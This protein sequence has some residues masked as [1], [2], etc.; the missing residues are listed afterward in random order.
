M[1]IK[2]WR[3]GCADAT[4]ISFMDDD[5]QHKNLF[6]DGG[7]LGTYRHTIKKELLRLQDMGEVVDLWIITHTDRDH[8]GGVEGFIRDRNFRGKEALVNEYWFNWSS[9]YFMP[10]G[11]NISTA[12]G[13]HLRDYLN[14]TGKL[15]LGDVITG[16]PATQFNGLT[17]T[18]LSPDTERLE[19][20]KLAWQAE[21]R[22]ILISSERSD[23]EKTIQTLAAEPFIQ[24][25]DPF[26]GGSIAFLLEENG[27]RILLLADSFPSVVQQSLEQLGYSADNRLKV[28]Y[29]KLSH[30]GSR[31]NFDPRL[32]DIVD[33]NRFII[34]ANGSTHQLPDKWTLAKILMHP[35]RSWESIQFYFNDDNKILRGIFDAD[36]NREAF[37]FECFYS[38]YPFLTIQFGQ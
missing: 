30:H 17:L 28:D 21:E 14:D 25:N 3:T 23:H 27:R 1:I 24:D 34:L 18:V 38:N 29:I 2:F 11:K 12:Q 33:C 31:R 6:I 26:N 9:Y 4:T 7:Y 36:N 16:M 10:G 5:G 32:L 8:I 20:S 37:N 22:E 35:L 19:K 15:C 13:I